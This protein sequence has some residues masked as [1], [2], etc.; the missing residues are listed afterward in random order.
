MLE[1]VRIT[2]G[3]FSHIKNQTQATNRPGPPPPPNLPASYAK[4]GWH[5]IRPGV[6]HR[7][8]ER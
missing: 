8:L 2:H 7:G 3:V 1:V 6:P 5:N 4:E